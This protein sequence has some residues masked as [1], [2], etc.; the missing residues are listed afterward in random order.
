MSAIH[1]I[2]PAADARALSATDLENLYAYPDDRMR[3][4]VNFVSS[5]D[6]AV[7]V[8]GSS[9]GLS[10]PP[11]RAVLDLGTDL[12]DVVLVAGGTATAEG[13]TGVEHN[14]R[15]DDRRR[16]FGLSELPSTAVVTSTGNS[17]DPSAPVLTDTVIPTIV[18]TSEAAPQDL[19]K[20]WAD[21]GADVV[22]TGEQGVDLAVALAE[23]ERRGLR[24]VNC[25]GGPSL[26]GSL[27]EA[28]LV[29]ELRLTLAPF[30]V[31]GEAGRIAHGAG[32]DPARLELLSV[33]T[34]DDTLLMRYR[35]R[36][37]P[38]T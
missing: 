21:A 25:M 13:F 5:A 24:R 32:M 27:A 23:L 4:C 28:G 9:A 18:L 3:V 33:V 30:L 26:F 6:G 29:D 14:D 22:V 37:T 1:Q 12:A 8:E 38:T 16:R 20:Q 35:V 34:G 36:A 17:L 31:S 19:R 7:E 10:T 15:M 2:F 11:D